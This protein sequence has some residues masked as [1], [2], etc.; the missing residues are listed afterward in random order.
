M[1]ASREKKKR[2]ELLASGVVDKKAAREAE[3][4]AAEHKSSKLYTAIAI[5]FVVVALALVVYNSHIIQRGQTALIVD[6]EKYT[7]ADVSYYYGNIYQNF[8]NSETGSMLMAYG[9]LDPSKPLDE[10]MAFGAEEGS[11]DAQTWAEYF[12][13]QTVDAIRQ[14]E[15]ALDLAEAEG[16]TLEDADQEA[17]DMTGRSSSRSCSCP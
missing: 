15:V 6:N 10:Q 16:M 11:E 12:Q 14:V 13:D 8:A 7:V 17:S 2:Q 9:M 3:K 4:K 1:S 5:A